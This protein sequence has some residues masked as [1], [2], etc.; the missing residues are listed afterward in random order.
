[1]M[2]FV[3]NYLLRDFLLG[4]AFFGV[5]GRTR[6]G[7]VGGVRVWWQGVSDGGGRGG[8]GSKLLVKGGFTSI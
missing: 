1:M 8:E 4:E 2:M 6:W 5:G 7:D 3:Y